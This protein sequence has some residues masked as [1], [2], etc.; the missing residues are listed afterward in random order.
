MNIDQDLYDKIMSEAWD[1]KRGPSR[2]P[3]RPDP[4]KFRAKC[5]GNL[6]IVHFY[7]DGCPIAVDRVEGD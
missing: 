7:H 3:L 2:F 6:W 5:D 4:V 1:V